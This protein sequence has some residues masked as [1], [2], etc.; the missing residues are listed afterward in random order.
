MNSIATS[1]RNTTTWRATNEWNTC[2]S[3][4]AG[5]RA[6]TMARERSAVARERN[7]RRIK[8]KTEVNPIIAEKKTWPIDLECLNQKKCRARFGLDQQSNWCKH[9]KWV[10]HVRRLSIHRDRSFSRRKKKCLRYTEDESTCVGPN[11]VGGGPWSEEDETDNADD[12]EDD[13][14]HCD[15]PLMEHSTSGNLHEG[16]G[17]HHSPLRAGISMDSDEENK[18]RLLMHQQPPNSNASGSSSSTNGTVPMSLLTSTSTARKDSS[19][20]SSSPQASFLHHRYSM[21]PPPPHFPHPYFDPFL[22]SSPMP[23]LNGLKRET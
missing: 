6:I 11:S 13:L 21:P 10:F 12:S 18:S 14:D 23:L 22:Q 3:T 1:N 2:N 19:S 9:C 7:A 15:I 20:S 5:Q 4:R 8:V 16:H 17:E